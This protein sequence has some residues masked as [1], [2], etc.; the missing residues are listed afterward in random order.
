MANDGDQQ[1]D[2]QDQVV[3]TRRSRPSQS[4]SHNVTFYQIQ[5]ATN[6]EVQPEEQVVVRRG[7]H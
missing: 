3:R 5:Q 6:D 1:E 2:Q 7:K 4:Q